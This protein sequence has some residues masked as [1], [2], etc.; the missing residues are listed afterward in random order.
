MLTSTVIHQSRRSL[1]KNASVVARILEGFRGTVGNTPLIRLPKLSKETGC[2]IL[3]KAEY[4]NPGGSIKDRAAFFLIQ[5]ALDKNLI[6]DGATIV[7]GTAGNTGI[8]LAHICNALGFKCVIFMPDNQSKEKIDLLRLLGAKVTTVPVVAFTD[9]NNYN[10]QAKRYADECDNALWTNQ[11]DNRANRQGHYVS[12][13]PEIW[14]QTNGKVDAVVM[15]TGT[16]GT[17]AGISMYLKEKNKN[18]RTVLADPPG[19]V[20]YHYIK[21]GKL[22]R[23]DGSSITEGLNILGKDLN[24]YAPIDESLF[25]SDQDS[26]NMVYKLL[27]E[28]GFFVGA[29]SGLNVA[30]AVELSKSMPKGSNIVTCICDNG[31][32]YYNRLFNKAELSKRGLLERIPAPYQKIIP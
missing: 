24:L 10:H 19:S 13:G 21:S 6:K 30:A 23:T 22:D 11:F 26:V 25:I 16:G 2:N 32:K 9:P 29:S 4:L 15:S 8:G 20:L 17:L 5:D 28:E 7:E 18:I 14:A 3:V 31:Q 27:C 12:T 1:S